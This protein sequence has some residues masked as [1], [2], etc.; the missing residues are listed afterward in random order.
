MSGRATEASDRDSAASYALVKL[1]H[2]G[3]LP[4]K[5]VDHALALGRGWRADDL[6][7]NLARQVCA[8]VDV[9]GSTPAEQAVFANSNLV[10][11]ELPAFAEGGDSSHCEEEE[12]R[13]EDAGSSMRRFLCDG[14]LTT[15]AHFSRW[16][17]R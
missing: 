14:K 8:A 13:E 1:R 4:N 6:H 15:C 17:R 9:P 2:D 12:G 16:S 3:H 7:R 5:A 11:V 10:V